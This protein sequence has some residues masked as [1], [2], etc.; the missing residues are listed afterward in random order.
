MFLLLSC[1]PHGVHSLWTVLFQQTPA[2]PPKP[3]THVPFWESFT[4]LFSQ[5]PGTVSP[6]SD[7]SLLSPCSRFPGTALL[8]QAVGF[9]A[10]PQFCYLLHSVWLPTGLHPYLLGALTW[11]HCCSSYSP[12][13]IISLVSF[14]HITLFHFPN[15]D[16]ATLFLLHVFEPPQSISLLVL[17]CCPISSFLPSPLLL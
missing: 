1:L 7:P 2:H 5:L 13:Y 6:F 3:S 14:T 8:L 11:I 10:K 17:P 16:I 4:S 12:H 9:F 15:S